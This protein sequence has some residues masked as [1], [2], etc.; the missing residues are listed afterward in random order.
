MSISRFA[1]SWTV[2][3]FLT[4]AAVLMATEEVRHRKNGFVPFSVNCKCFVSK[5]QCVK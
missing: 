5:S 1:N 3:K 4:L 2:W